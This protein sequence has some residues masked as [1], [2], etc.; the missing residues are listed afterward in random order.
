MTTRS[1]HRL[2]LEWGK[3]GTKGAMV[4]RSTAERYDAKQ[5]PV[6]EPSA[7]R[8]R[9]MRVHMCMAAGA[10]GPIIAPMQTARGSRAA[11]LQGEYEYVLIVWMT[12]MMVAAILMRPALVTSTVR[13]PRATTTGAVVTPDTAADRA[14]ASTTGQAE[15]LPV[16]HAPHEMTRP[17]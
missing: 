7:T 11:S 14:A 3:E 17:I 6:T 9:A 2:V 16:H 8:S 13:A 12:A 4:M 15:E 1:Q 10:T 5:S